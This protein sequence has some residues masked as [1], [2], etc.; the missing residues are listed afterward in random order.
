[1]TELEQLGKKVVDARAAYTV[2]PDAYK[3]A[4]FVAYLKAMDE[5][6]NYIKEQD[7]E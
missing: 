5:L 4:A 3:D 6:K 2:A 7:N 1:M